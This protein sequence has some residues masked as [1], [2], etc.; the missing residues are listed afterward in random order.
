[1][2]WHIPGCYSRPVLLPTVAFCAGLTWLASAPVTWAWDRLDYAAGGKGGTAFEASCGENAVLVGIRG[3]AGQTVDQVQGL[4][5]KVDPVSGSWIGGVYQTP[6]FGGG[7]GSPFVMQCDVGS[8]V[9]RIM[10]HTTYFPVYIAQL[11]IACAT[12]VRS[13]ALPQY[14]VTGGRVNADTPT[15]GARP[16]E[17]KN[18]F[19][20]PCY[21]PD[22]HLSHVLREDKRGYDSYLHDG[23]IATGLIGRSGSLIDAI[24]VTCAFIDRPLK[25]YQVKI[26]VQP[27]VPIIYGMPVKAQWNVSGVTPELTPPMDFS[28]TVSRYPEGYGL[29]VVA[30]KFPYPNGGSF[31]AWVPIDLLPVTG[32]PCPEPNHTGC[33]GNP[34]RADLG[35]LRPGR[36]KLT[37]TTHLRGFAFQQNE[38]TFEVRENRP[39][40][41]ALNPNPASGGM[42]VTGTV[43]IEGPAPRSGKVIH[44]YSSSP[45]LVGVP[46]TVQ[47]P[48]GATSATFLASISPQIREPVS[49]LVRASD[50]P[51]LSQMAAQPSVGNTITSRGVEPEALPSFAESTQE[52]RQNPEGQAGGESTDLTERG[53]GSLSPG[54][55]R[56]Q[57]P[58]TSLTGPVA[59]APVPS[60]PGLPHAPSPALRPSTFSLDRA[61]LKGILYFPPEVVLNVV[62]ASPL[63]Q[64]PDKQSPLGGRIP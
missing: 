10:G 45:E 58:I 43:S 63:R 61:E 9:V 49:V 13:D 57:T 11:A 25:D 29:G 53:V 18:E 4:C 21:S 47:V 38:T 1:M 33:S 41:V 51:P 59:A 2:R 31:T 28:W 42:N 16:P 12:I 24:D 54:K 32:S 36:Y 62:P 48:A 19:S 46:A 14:L 56:L 44:L 30:R 6:A 20:R 15:V 22:A 26:A 35:E 52:S 50:R 27:A 3:R 8:A 7:G 5:V 39:V 34:A 60:V 55:A 17:S 23:A 37:V 64:Q 40:S